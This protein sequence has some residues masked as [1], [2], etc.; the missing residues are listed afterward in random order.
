MT[1]GKGRT[2]NPNGRPKGSTNKVNPE[3]RVMITDFLN[4]SFTDV[5]KEFNNL[6]GKD[7]LKF[8][9][10]MLQYGLPKLQATTL[11]ID[12]DSMTDEQLDYIVNQLKDTTA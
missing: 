3:L 10:D 9:S 11:E 4:G 2:N 8:Y 6:E 1:A 12:F 5:I 7:K